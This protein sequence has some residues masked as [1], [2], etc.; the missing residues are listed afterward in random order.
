MWLPF[1]TPRPFDDKHRDS[2]LHLPWIRRLFI[3]E[4]FIN[5]KAWIILTSIKKGLECWGKKQVMETHLFTI[6]C[7][8]DV[9][10]NG[11]RL[12]ILPAGDGQW[13]GAATEFYI[14]AEDTELLGQAV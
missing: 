7:V 11:Y 12:D 8:D 3:A 2:H 6:V 14:L 1:G 13:H 10:A 5:E 4:T 9:F